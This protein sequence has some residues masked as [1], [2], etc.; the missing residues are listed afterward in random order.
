VERFAPSISEIQESLRIEDGEIGQSLG[1]R[2]LGPAIDEVGVLGVSAGRGH[3]DAGTGLAVL[4]V[5]FD[6]NIAKRVDL[7][8]VLWRPVDAMVGAACVDPR[9][10]PA[11]RLV[12][13]LDRFGIVSVD[14]D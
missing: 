9:R 3:A 1:A 11:P 10:R 2:P 13:E 6:P 12:G 7:D 5:D 4:D 8:R 14:D